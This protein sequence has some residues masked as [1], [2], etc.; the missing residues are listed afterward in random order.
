MGKQKRRRFTTEQ[1]ATMLRRHLVDKVPVSD[2]RDDSLAAT[3]VG[4]R[5]CPDPGPAPR[6]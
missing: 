2:L 5:A 6:Q 3:A 4:Y 1:K